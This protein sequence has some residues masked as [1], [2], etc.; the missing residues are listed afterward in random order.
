MEHNAT[1]QAMQKTISALEKKLSSLEK[2]IKAQAAE[3]LKL[4]RQLA[5]QQDQLYVVDYKAAQAL[6][7]AKGNR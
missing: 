1:I 2:Q 5:R 6:Q 7:Y 3:S 4:K